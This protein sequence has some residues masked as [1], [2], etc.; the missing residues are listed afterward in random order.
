MHLNHRLKVSSD[1]TYVGYFG[2]AN[3]AEASLVIYETIL[4]AR[5]RKVVQI[6]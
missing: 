6:I 5:P 3:N 1:L 4:R 2:V